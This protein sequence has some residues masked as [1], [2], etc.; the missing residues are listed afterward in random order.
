M[1]ADDIQADAGRASNRHMGGNGHV[2]R[3][4]E[5]IKRAMRFA[6]TR[7]VMASLTTILDLPMTSQLK[8]LRLCRLPSS[9]VWIEWSLGD[10]LREGV[11]ICTEDGITQRGTCVTAVRGEGLVAVM[12]SQ[13]SFDWRENPEA[14]SDTPKPASEEEWSA[15]IARD[16]EL[17]NEKREAWND[18]TT[19]HAVVLDPNGIL[20]V[21]VHETRLREFYHSGLVA[22]QKARAIIL[23]MNTKNIVGMEPCVPDAKLQKARVKSGKAPLFDHTKIEI[24]L[25][26]SMAAR[27][28][29]ASDPRNPMRL[30]IVR[31]HFKI[32]KTG[33][34]WW[35]DH[36]RGLPEAGEI[37]HQIRKITM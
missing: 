34:F 25:S 27:V 35:P 37:T 22:L 32:R 14:V 8:T 6:A 28:G 24:R 17:R 19:R 30:H 36:A 16:P 4:A 29:E 9:V 18:F 13:L 31:G 5:Q 10:G 33:I 15:L 11:L 26:K 7:E 3:F 1:L 20:P 12:P 23:L 2:A 21:D